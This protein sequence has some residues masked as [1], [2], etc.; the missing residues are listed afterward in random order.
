MVVYRWYMVVCGGMWWYAVVCGGMQWYAVVCGGMRWYAVVCSGI[1]WYVPVCGGGGF[2]SHPNFVLSWVGLWQLVDKQVSQWLWEKAW[3]QC[4][5]RY[6][7]WKMAWRQPVI[8]LPASHWSY[9]SDL[10]KQSTL[11]CLRQTEDKPKTNTRRTGNQR[12]D[13]VEDV[14]SKIERP[15]KNTCSE[16]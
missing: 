7:S 16:P 3:N 5:L 14:L 12:K 4:L 13:E 6:V 1:G 2:Y 11:N 10:T 9:A 15:H 8:N